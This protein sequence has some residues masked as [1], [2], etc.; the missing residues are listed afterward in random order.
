M[1]RTAWPTVNTGDS[2]SA[3][4]HNTYGRD[5]D[6]AYWKGVAAGDTDYYTGATDKA[7]LAIG[8]PGQ[9]YT[10]NPGA[11]AP[12]WVNGGMTLIEE[13]IA[14]G[15][16]ATYTFAAIPQ[17]YSHLKLIVMGRGEAAAFESDVICQFNADV[18]VNYGYNIVLIG[19][20]IFTQTY[21]GA[22]GAIVLGGITAANAPANY[23][24]VI[25]TIIPNYSN[26]TFYKVVQ[27]LASSIWAANIG[28]CATQIYHAIWRSINAITAIKVFF[29][30]GGHTFAAGT[31]I[32]LY[33][34][35]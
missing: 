18:G 33:G 1:G 25:E 8:T 30:G 20:N 24:G 4:Q 9:K 35:V 11:T 32:S 2:W 5:N 34:M 10:V 13:F 22:Q 28:G 14:T 26:A 6:L 16:E 15:G 7:V 19:N 17:I 23:S 21:N 3:G 31:I 12:S 27:T 29:L